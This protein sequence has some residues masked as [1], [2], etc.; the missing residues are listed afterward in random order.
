MRRLPALLLGVLVAFSPAAQANG[1]FCEAASAERTCC[2]GGEGPCPCCP[3]SGRDGEELAPPCACEMPAP[4]APQADVELLAAPPACA[5]LD[6]PEPPSGPDVSPAQRVERRDPH[7][8]L[9]L[10]LL[11]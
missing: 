5:I 11:L 10:P 4:Q 7:P 2:C 8:G 6:H 1:C 3:A 9:L